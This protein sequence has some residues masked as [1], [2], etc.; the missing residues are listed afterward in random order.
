MVQSIALLNVYYYI[1]YDQ[2]NQWQTS[3]FYRGE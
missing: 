1:R 3:I 2:Y